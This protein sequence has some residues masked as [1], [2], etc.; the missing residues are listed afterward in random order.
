M[1]KFLVILLA[2]VAVGAF[3]FSLEDLKVS[4]FGNYNLRHLQ[5]PMLRQLITWILVSISHIR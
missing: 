5:L 4:V 1:K 3:A 2:V